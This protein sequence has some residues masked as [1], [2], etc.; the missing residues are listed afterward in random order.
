MALLVWLYVSSMI[1]LLGAELTYAI[2]KERRGLR[3]DQQLRVIA[4]PGVQPTPKFAP[5]VGTGT[6]AG[7]DAA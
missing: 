5:Q 6:D 3:P 1:I 7:D 2:A 4:P